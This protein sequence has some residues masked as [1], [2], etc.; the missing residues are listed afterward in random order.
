MAR[1]RPLRNPPITEALVDFRVALPVQARADAFAALGEILG[2]RFPQ[3]SPI[4][5]LAAHFTV[6]GSRAPSQ[7]QALHG[8]MF[9][10]SDG[11]DIAQFRLD[12]FTFNRLKPYP[13]WE[14]FFSQALDLW[15]LYLKMASPEAVTRVAVRYINHLTLPAVPGDLSAFLTVPPTL[16]GTVPGR[17]TGFVSRLNVHDSESGLSAYVTQACEG[18]AEPGSLTVTLDIDSYRISTTPQDSDDWFLTFPVLRG[19]KNS[20]FF[21]S[22]TEHTAEIYE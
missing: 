11:L 10:S 12:G 1:I 21:G 19:F 2:S 22:I 6:G 15:Y 16:P 17:L 18:G 3:S 7:E 4:V 9:K 20:L 5:S 13:G 14:A 8:Y